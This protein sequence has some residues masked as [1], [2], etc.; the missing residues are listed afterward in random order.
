MA[1]IFK[2]DFPE[3]AA[4]IVSILV[5]DGL[6]LAAGEIVRQIQENQTKSTKGTEKWPEKKRI[7][8]I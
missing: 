4:K 6:P 2:E 5:Y 8:S 3:L 1:G 7:A